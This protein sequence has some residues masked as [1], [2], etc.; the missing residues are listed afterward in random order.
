V[1]LDAE[2]HRWQDDGGESGSVATDAPLDELSF[3]YYVRTLP[4]DADTTLRI[5]RHFDPARNPTLVRVLEH[6]T[7]TT[8]SGTFRTVLVEMRVQDPR[9]YHG[10]GVIRL[11]LTDDH[12]RIPVRIESQMPV[13]G[14]ATMLL[15]TQNHPPEH[16]VALLP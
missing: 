7:V 8:A 9:R 10:E 3:M 14:R 15:E 11:D 5:E 4:L 1:E 6:R 12:C 2:A 16:H 13:V